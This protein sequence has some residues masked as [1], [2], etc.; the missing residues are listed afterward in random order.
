MR[1]AT[2]KRMILAS[3]L[4][5]GLAGL[6]AAAQV[7]VPS[8]INH[9]GYVEVNGEPFTGTG[10]FRF[11]IVDGNGDNVWTHDGSQLG[12][13]A[14]PVTA[15]P[16]MVSEGVYSIALGMS[17]T[18]P[19]PASVFTNA[20]LKLRVWFD[21]GTNGVQQLTPDQPLLSVAFARAAETAAS[22]EEAQSVTPGAVDSGALA[23]GAVDSAAIA[24]GAVDSADIADGSISSI[25][26]GDGEVSAVDIAN[27]AVTTVEIADDTV[28]T[29]DFASGAKAPDADLLDGTDSS[30]FATSAH[31]HDG[32][33]IDSG[34]MA[35][36][37]LPDVLQL[38]R[39][40]YNSPRQ[41]QLTIPAAG[42][43]PGRPGI[44]WLA[45]QTAANTQGIGQ[46]AAPVLLPDGAT[47]TEVEFIFFDNDPD[48]EVELAFG[49]NDLD[50]ATST[51][52]ATLS[53]TGETG[54]PRTVSSGPLSVTIDGSRAYHLTVK[55]ASG[56][57]DGNQM[58]LNGVR[59]TY[60]LDE[61]R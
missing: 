14:M 49:S 31:T 8:G 21:D 7:N 43:Q 29:P 47:V 52:H 4:M 35:E 53:T 19:I 23:P 54:G 3:S 37:R 39:V 40:E 44:S 57:W 45:F 9:Q 10:N 12:N 50:S 2:F 56:D 15:V 36:A 5:A 11:A 46:F 25:D 18:D 51:T 26:I 20:E 60:Q 33:D 13:N 42:F 30:G 22:A 58:N 17:P 24:G 59:L 34:T 27:G 55:D 16:R 28:G 38:D 41:Y 48:S 6:P 1:C 61:A 32:S